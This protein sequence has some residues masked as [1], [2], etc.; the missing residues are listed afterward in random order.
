MN[1]GKG[2]QEDEVMIMMLDTKKVIGREHA[3]N[4]GLLFCVV[5]K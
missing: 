5:L 3:V 2:R 1:Q 4:T